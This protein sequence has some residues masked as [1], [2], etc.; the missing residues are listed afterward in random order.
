MPR[1]PAEPPC[2]PR[3]SKVPTG[4]GEP[5]LMLSSCRFLS[6]SS[7]KS[8][9]QTQISPAGLFRAG[10]TWLLILCGVFLHGSLLSWDA[11]GAGSM[12]RCMGEGL[13]SHCLLALCSEALKWCW[14]KLPELIES[15]TLPKLAPGSSSSLTSFLCCH[16][17]CNFNP[18]KHLEDAE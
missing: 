3:L 18:R 11:E 2:R 10:P 6:L 4:L 5:F 12:H 1:S 7:L 16:L 13:C 15:I 9:H 17:R 14:K 8:A